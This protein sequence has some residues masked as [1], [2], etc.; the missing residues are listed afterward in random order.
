MLIFWSLKRMFWRCSHW[1]R[2]L[3]PTCLTLL[4]NSIRSRCRHTERRRCGFLDEAWTE[5]WIFLWNLKYTPA[6]SSGKYVSLWYFFIVKYYHLRISL[7]FFF[8]SQI[9]FSISFLLFPSTSISKSEPPIVL[10]M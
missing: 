9:S 8:I 6:Y 1:R 4:I 3:I 10:L 5:K 7:N 2:N